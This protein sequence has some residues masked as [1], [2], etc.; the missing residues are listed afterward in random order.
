MARRSVGVSWVLVMPALAGLAFGYELGS[1][2]PPGNGENED[3]VQ[4]CPA[5][6]C[7]GVLE[8]KGNRLVC[9]D[10]GRDYPLS[11]PPAQPEANGT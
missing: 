5:E 4:N 1:F 7:D 11:P 9:S 10:C 2:L 3:D 6:G 8:R